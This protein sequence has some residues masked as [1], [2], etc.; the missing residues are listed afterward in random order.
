MRLISFAGLLLLWAGVW[1]Y[2]RDRESWRRLNRFAIAALCFSGVGVIIDM[3][4]LN[5]PALGARWLKFY[6]FRLADI[7]LPTSVALGLAVAAVKLSRRS[8]PAARLL[9]GTSLLASSLLIGWQY[10]RL[11]IDF[12][13]AAISQSEPVAFRDASWAMRRYRAWRDACAWIARQ[14]PPQSRFLTPRNQQTFKWYAGRAELVCWKDI[15][16]DAASIVE[17]WRL[18]QQIYTPAVCVGGL[19]AWSDRQLQQIADTHHLD[20]ILVDRRHCAAGWDFNAFIPTPRP[21][22]TQRN[23]KSIAY[24]IERLS[25]IPMID[26]LH[27]QLPL[28]LARRLREPLPGRRAHRR[29]RAELAYGRHFGPPASDARQAAVLV[30]LVPR[31]IHWHIPLTLRP[32]HMV[33]HAGQISLPGGTSE[34]GETLRQCALR[35][36][37]EELGADESKL[38]V[39]GQLSPLYVFASNFFVTPWMAVVDAAPCWHPNPHEVQRVLELPLSTLLDPGQH[40]V[41]LLH[42]R[43]YHFASR[44]IQCGEDRI[45]GATGMILME[46]AQVVRDALDPTSMP[47][48]QALDVRE[49]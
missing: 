16:Q 12:R 40:A 1:W 17:W 49:S 7:A 18:M 25:N 36:Y 9:W 10:T 47:Q 14:T 5:H 30:C 27:D 4:T 2:I 11:Q 34:E 39:L 46:V 42:R 15:P 23:M 37:G 32:A 29:M 48:D 8:V 43:G 35:E 19:G 41:H 44:H 45:W 21:A 24:T 3:A 20:Y 31:G 38:T 28:R 26:P 22:G 6:W 33:D 13:P